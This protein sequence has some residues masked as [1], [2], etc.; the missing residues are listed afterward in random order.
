MFS[1]DARG[2][3]GDVSHRARIPSYHVVPTLNQSQGS[4]RVLDMENRVLLERLTPPRTYLI[5]EMVRALTREASLG[6]R[7]A[8]YESF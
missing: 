2:L 8:L 6:T 1:G 4:G 3:Y 7:D 5:R